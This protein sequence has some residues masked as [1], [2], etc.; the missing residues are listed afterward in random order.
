MAYSLELSQTTVSTSLTRIYGNEHLG[1][2][3]TTSG[4]SIAMTNYAPL[5]LDR[6][7][8][9]ETYSWRVDTTN[10]FGSTAGDLWS[11]STIGL[12]ATLTPWGQLRYGCEAIGRR[13]G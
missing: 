1:Q 7:G 3:F 9:S 11:F 8:C 13:R 5:H 6:P 4:G 10:E 2:L 12:D